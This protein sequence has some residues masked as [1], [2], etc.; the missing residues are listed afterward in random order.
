MAEQCNKRAPAAAPAAA[1]TAEQTVKCKRRLLYDAARVAYVRGGGGG[2]G[3]GGYACT[4]V[5]VFRL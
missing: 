3:G 5:I 1:A 4:A 2:G